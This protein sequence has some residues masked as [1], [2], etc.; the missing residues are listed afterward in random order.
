MPLVKRTTLLSDFITDPAT[1]RALRELNLSTANDLIKWDFVN[2]N[3]SIEDTMI[4]LVLKA[5]NSI[6]FDAMQTKYTFTD[7]T[8]SYTSEKS[9]GGGMAAY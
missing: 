6:S 3:T 7:K 8:E 1:L 4:S 9:H 5:R 2:L